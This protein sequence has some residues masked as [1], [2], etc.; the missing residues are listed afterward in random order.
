MSLLILATALGAPVAHVLAVDGQAYVTSDGEETAARPGLDIDETDTIETGE[1]ALLYLLLANNRVVKIEEDLELPASGISLLK[2]PPIDTPPGEQLAALL[3]PADSERLGPMINGAQS[4]GG[5]H[6]RPTA[7]QTLRGGG[8]DAVEEESDNVQN[9][10]Y[11]DAEENA[12]AEPSAPG[13]SELLTP[14]APGGPTNKCVAKWAKKTLGK[15]VDSFEIQVHV[16]DGMV[17]A[18][19]T[20]DGEALPDCVLE[21]VVG[22]SVDASLENEGYLPPVNVVIR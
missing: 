9:K 5:W 3:E 22:K 4:V 21:L 2:E 18:A 15:K 17:D 8:G 7:A 10:A 14:A 12:P 13:L 16:T 6:A 1:E 19:N 20:T 11:G